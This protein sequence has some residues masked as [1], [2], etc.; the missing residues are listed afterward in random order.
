MNDVNV[1]I[2][3]VILIGSIMPIIA[4]IK[5]ARGYNKIE[6]GASI[7]ALEELVEAIKESRCDQILHRETKKQIKPR[8]QPKDAHN[9]SRLTQKALLGENDQTRSRLGGLTVFISQRS[10]YQLTAAVTTAEG[11]SVLAAI[12]NCRLGGILIF[13]WVRSTRIESPPAK[14]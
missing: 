14:L 7:E 9:N 13:S 12:L 6:T 1:M 4:G 10:S 8:S 11:P 2:A 5:L 3:I